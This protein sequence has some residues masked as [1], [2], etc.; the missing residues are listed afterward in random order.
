MLLSIEVVSHP[1]PKYVWMHDGKHIFSN[2]TNSSSSVD[3]N[4]S[5]K[6]FGKYV[7]NVSNEAGYF[8]QEYEIL[9]DGRNYFLFLND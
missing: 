4:V 8:T 3:L 6:D 1:P 5:V 9:A 2:D 7:L